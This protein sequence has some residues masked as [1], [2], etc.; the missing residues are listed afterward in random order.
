MH[1]LR[2]II[3]ICYAVLIMHADV[4][5]SSSQT[6][7]KVLSCRRSQA[8]AQSYLLFWGSRQSHGLQRYSMTFGMLHA[9]E[10]PMPVTH[11]MHL[12]NQALVKSGAAHVATHESCAVLRLMNHALCACQSFHTT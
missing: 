8:A 7:A 12:S 10:L 3:W 4:Q 11:C 6:V 1:S 5:A 9:S 2:Y